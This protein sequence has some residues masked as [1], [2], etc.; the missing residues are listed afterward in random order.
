MRIAPSHARGHPGV[1][2]ASQRRL[3][4]IPARNR[5]HMRAT[6]HTTRPR[7]AIP[8]PSSTTDYWYS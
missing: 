1:P 7:Q 2:I 6:L 8:G 4:I 3:I 5:A